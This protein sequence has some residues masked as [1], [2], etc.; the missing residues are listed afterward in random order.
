MAFSLEEAGG[1]RCNLC[2]ILEIGRCEVSRLLP[3]TLEV[4]PDASRRCRKPSPCG[5]PVFF[6]ESSEL[7]S[8]HTYL[9]SPTL[10]QGERHGARSYFG[11]G[12]DLY[13]GVFL[14]SWG[15]GC[16]HNG[17]IRCSFFLQQRNN[18]MIAIFCL[19]SMD[20]SPG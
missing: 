19:V 5:V 12:G 20:K 15:W 3:P 2:P 14:S 4:P 17:D 6:F 11:R 13:W 1:K 7:C 16:L 10:P 8:P 9:R 18:A